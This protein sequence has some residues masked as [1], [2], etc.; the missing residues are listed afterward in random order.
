VATDGPGPAHDRV[1]IAYEVRAVL[2]KGVDRSLVSADAQVEIALR[3]GT[4]FAGNV[5]ELDARHAWALGVRNDPS[6]ATEDPLVALALLRSSHVRMSPEVR[7]ALLRTHRTNP[8]VT[9]W[10]LSAG[11]CTEQ[12]SSFAGSAKTAHERSL[13]Q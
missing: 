7:G 10:C 9:G 12:R 8:L 11:G 4:S 6:M 2:D 13:V 1:R 3:A 5:G